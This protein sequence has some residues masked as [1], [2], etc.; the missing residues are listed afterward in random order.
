MKCLI[1]FKT[2]NGGALAVDFL[3]KIRYN[4]VGLAISL[5]NAVLGR[6]NERL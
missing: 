1:C 3:L 2:D 5:E 6:K 4:V